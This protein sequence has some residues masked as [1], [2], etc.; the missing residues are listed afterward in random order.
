[1]TLLY[2]LALVRIPPSTIIYQ[3][4]DPCVLAITNL[5]NNEVVYHSS[6]CD[7][8]KSPAIVAVF[9]TLVTRRIGLYIFG[10]HPGRGGDRE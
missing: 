3:T 4:F 8:G 6:Y 5:V 10:L 2:C 9:D 1:M 7:C